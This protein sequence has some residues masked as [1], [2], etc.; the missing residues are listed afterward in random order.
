L[1]ENKDEFRARV[2]LPGFDVKDLAVTATPNALIVRAEASHTHEGKQGEVRFCEFSGKQMFRRLDLPSEI[3]VDKVTAS[4]DKGIL[5]ITAPKAA[6]RRLQAAARAHASDLWRRPA[7]TVL[8]SPRRMHFASHPSHRIVQPCN[9]GTA[10]AILYSLVHI[11]RIDQ[12]AIVA[13]LPS[14]HY[15]SDE[16]AFTEA[17]ESAFT[18]SA[19]RSQS[20]IL[21][22]AQPNFAEVEYFLQMAWA[23]TPG[24]LEDS[25]ERLHSAFQ[26][27]GRPSGVQSEALD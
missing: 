16:S 6:A 22:G 15:Y 3:D 19:V 17:L 1:I 24:F 13:I 7:E 14:D 2:A 10:P 4:L 23:A 8:P 18:M 25:R 26:G 20:A 21:L 9:R 11:A 5:E 12:N 27:R